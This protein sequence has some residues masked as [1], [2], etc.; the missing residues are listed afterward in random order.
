MIIYKKN[1]RQKSD[2]WIFWHS[3]YNV[4]DCDTDQNLE[5]DNEEINNKNKINLKKDQIKTTLKY[6]L[7]RK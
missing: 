6:G 4:I 1:F 5:S 2:E 3:A 7:Q